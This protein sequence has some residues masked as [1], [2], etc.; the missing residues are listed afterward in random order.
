MDYSWK[1]KRKKSAF[2]TA[3]K[4]NVKNLLFL[5]LKME[6]YLKDILSEQKW[7]SL[8]KLFLIQV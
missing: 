1:E 4:K 7:I 2:L 6:K 3:G 5:L 8:E